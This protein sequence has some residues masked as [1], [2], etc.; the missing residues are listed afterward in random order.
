MTFQEPVSYAFSDSPSL[1]RGSG[2][3]AHVDP[4]DASVPSCDDSTKQNLPEFGEIDPGLLALLAAVVLP[5][6]SS[7]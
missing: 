6:A 4:D 7:R 3:L 1:H 5:K 2:F